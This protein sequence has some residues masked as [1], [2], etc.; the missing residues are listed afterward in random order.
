MTSYLVQPIKHHLACPRPTDYSPGIQPII[1]ARRF[2]AFPSGHAT[3][4]FV[5][6]RLLQ[7]LS[8]QDAHVGGAETDLEKQLQRLA[9]RISNNRVIAGVH[10]PIDAAAGR[11]AGETIAE[12]LLHRSEVEGKGWTPRTFLGSAL[13]EADEEVSCGFR[14]SE[15][16]DA[17]W[18]GSEAPPK[19]FGQNSSGPVFPI[20]EPGLVAFGKKDGLL[21]YLWKQASKEWAHA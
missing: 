5:I 15:R 17:G 8:G 2:A 16:L 13:S 11:M 10:F 14:R 12:Y 19:H 3:E 1:N 18:P 4:A 7:R 21:Q 20:L 9:M 6:A